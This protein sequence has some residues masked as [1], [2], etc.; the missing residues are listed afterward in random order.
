MRENEVVI[1]I[2]NVKKQY[3]L[4]AIGGGTLQGDLQSWW[5]RVRGKEDPN[6]KIG[7]R[8]Y[9]KNETFMALNGMG[10]TAAKSLADA[11]MEKPFDTVEEI[12]KRAKIN[13]STIDALRARGVLKGM[14]E[15]D[16]LS[17]F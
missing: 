5:A 10:E 9:G 14:P 4:G 1:K 16:Q 3:R 6:L 13:K 8:Q 17:F 11:Y 2:D 12:S 7:E 15:T